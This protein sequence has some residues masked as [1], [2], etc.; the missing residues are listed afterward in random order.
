MSS[1][2]DQFLRSKEKIKI[3]ANEIKPLYGNKNWQ[4]YKASVYAPCYNLLSSSSMTGF[5]IWNCIER[6]KLVK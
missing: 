3:D 4:K 1:I 6:I 5:V 2:L